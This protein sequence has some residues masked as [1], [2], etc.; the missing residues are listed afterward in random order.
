[1]TS[2]TLVILHIDGPGNH[3]ILFMSFLA[4]SAGLRLP[5]LFLFR[6]RQ[7]F[8]V[9]WFPT[10]SFQP[11]LHAFL[12]LTALVEPYDP[13]FLNPDGDPDFATLIDSFSI[14][15]FVFFF[16]LPPPTLRCCWR[17]SA[18]SGSPTDLCFL[19]LLFR[20]APP[21]C[22][23]GLSPTLFSLPELYPLIGP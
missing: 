11:T 1:V 22:H 19:P 10:A 8:I 15:M 14:S 18:F 7:V 23:S 6:R 9:K 12:R 21:Y 5:S 20:S 2:K 16:L 3:H 13:R 4:W 17:L